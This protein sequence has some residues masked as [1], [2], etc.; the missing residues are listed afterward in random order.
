MSCPVMQA[1][2]RCLRDCYQIPVG[3]CILRKEFSRK[4]MMNYICIYPLSVSQCYLIQ[5][6]ISS[7]YIRSYSFPLFNI[8]FVICHDT[9]EHEKGSIELMEP[10]RNMRKRISRILFHFHHITE[11]CMF[12]YDLLFFDIFHYVLL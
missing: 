12:L 5:E 6:S 11:P 9:S 1:V 8:Q 7:K 10:E 4:D 3:V 2:M